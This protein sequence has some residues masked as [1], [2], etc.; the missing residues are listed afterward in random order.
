MA[1]E[2]MIFISVERFKELLVY[3]W[4]LLPLEKQHDLIALGVHPR[5]VVMRK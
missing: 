4:H 1:E 3:G 2:L 5:A